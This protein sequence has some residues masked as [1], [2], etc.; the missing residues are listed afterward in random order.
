MV[1]EHHDLASDATRYLGHTGCHTGMTA[2]TKPS[3][4][5]DLAHMTRT[6]AAQVIALTLGMAALSVLLRVLF[7][8]VT[9]AHGAS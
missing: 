5:P 9:T 1:R 2:S 3:P 8:G 7:Q 6:L 4:A